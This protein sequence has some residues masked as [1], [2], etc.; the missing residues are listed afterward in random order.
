M[1]ALKRKENKPNFTTPQSIAMKSKPKT[2]LGQKLSKVKKV[3]REPLWKGPEDDGPLGGITQSMLNNFC[4]CRERFRVKYVEGLQPAQ[5]FNRVIEYG[6]MWHCAE[7]N[8]AARQDWQKPLTIYCQKLCQKYPLAQDE[9]NKWYNIC[10]VQFPLYVKWWSEHED[11]VQR[12]PLLQEEVFH[13]PYKLP[14]GRTVYLR[15]KFD[16]VDLVGKGKDAGIYLKENKTKSEIDSTRIERQMSFDLQTM[17]YLVAL[18]AAKYDDSKGTWT[19]G[20]NKSGSGKRVPI[21]GVNY[22]VVRRP[23]SGGRGSITQ[24]KG[25]DGSVCSGCDGKGERTMYA[26]TKREVFERPCGKCEGKGRTGMK[27]PETDE[28]FGERLRGI[29][30]GAVG[31][32]W[33]MPDGQHFF[34][35]RWKVEIS[36]SDVERFKTRFLHPI[37]ESLCNWYGSIKNNIE[38]PWHSYPPLDRPY[39]ETDRWKGINH[40]H[41]QLPFGIYSPLAENGFTDVDEYLME[42][43]DVGLHRAMTLFTEL[44]E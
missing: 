9:I 27:P 20:I 16:S 42:G 15:G 7:E 33:G 8:F 5:G 44:A 34:F 11:V 35:M 14:S 2:K 31:Q 24:G 37:L 17:M 32:E 21:R 1:P 41:Y 3:E 43:N 4:S 13:V 36:P 28:E 22:N 38:D 10:L 23:L 18:D 39:N 40:H 6:N 19:G 12:T 25:S 30:E 29:I 26:G